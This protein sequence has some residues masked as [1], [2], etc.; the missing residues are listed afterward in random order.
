[1]NALDQLAARIFLACVK[2]KIKARGAG[3]LK[4]SDFRGI[5]TRACEIAEVFLSELA[6]YTK[7]QESP[8]PPPGP[9]APPTTN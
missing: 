2:D 3:K 4:A 1:M 8:E 9:E 6:A 5:G 7:A